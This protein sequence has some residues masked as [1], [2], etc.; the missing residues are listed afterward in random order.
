MVTISKTGGPGL[1]FENEVVRLEV[2][3][4]AGVT[5]GMCL[6]IELS[7]GEYKKVNKSGVEGDPSTKAAALLGIA[8]EDGVN[9]QKI[10]VGVRGM[11]MCL[12]SSNVVIGVVLPSYSPGYLKPQYLNPAS[13]ADHY[14]KVIGIAVEDGPA[15][16]GDYLTKVLFDGITGFACTAGTS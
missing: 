14:E 15:V 16:S 9:G 6:E 13:S 4:A 3:E 2:N 12:T 11:F 8:M 7:D 10:R 5:K 1:R